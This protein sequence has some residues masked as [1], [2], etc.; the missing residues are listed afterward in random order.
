MERKKRLL[1][2]RGKQH[3]TN[4]YKRGRNMKKQYKNSNAVY[5][6]CWING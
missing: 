4:K 5:A 3:E 2:A 1:G 6:D